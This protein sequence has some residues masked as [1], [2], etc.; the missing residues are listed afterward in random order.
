MRNMS[1]DK[2]HDEEVYRDGYSAG[3]SGSPKGSN[4]YRHANSADEV[5]WDRGWERANSGKEYDGWE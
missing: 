4:P 5:L 3:I 2:F 1:A